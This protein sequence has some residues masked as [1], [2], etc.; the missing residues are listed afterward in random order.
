MDDF[1]SWHYDNKGIFSVKSA[2]QL[3]VS[4]KEARK[5]QDARV[6]LCKSGNIF[7]NLNYRGR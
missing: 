6:K 3:G 4:L 5:N 1:L 7:G 2:Y